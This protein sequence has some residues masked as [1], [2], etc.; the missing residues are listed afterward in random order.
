[1]SN[2][3]YMNTRVGQGCDPVPS[4]FSICME[5]VKGRPKSLTLFMLSSS[6]HRVT[7]GFGGGSQGTTTIET[8]D[9]LGQFGGLLDEVV[10]FLNVC[11]KDIKILENFTYLG[12]IGQHKGR[13]YQENFHEISSLTHSAWYCQY[14]SR[15][16]KIVIAQ[17]VVLLVLLYSWETNKILT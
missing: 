16:I 12:S 5:W 3:V 2:F 8:E 14:L 10:H 6:P 13:S 17:S 1:M 9:L 11:G 4:L 7:G 15:R